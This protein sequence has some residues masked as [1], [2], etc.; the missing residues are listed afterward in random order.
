VILPLRGL[1]QKTGFKLCLKGIRKTRFKRIS[2]PEVTKCT[3]KAKEAI[4]GQIRGVFRGFW[5]SL[6][7]WRFSFV[8]K[9]GKMTA[10]M[11]RPDD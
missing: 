3:S 10:K 8:Q 7:D 1:L 2:L 4:L 9:Q 5:I 6:Q 11:R